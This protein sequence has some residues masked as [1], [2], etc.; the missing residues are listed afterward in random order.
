LRALAV[1]PVLYDNHVVAALNLGSHNAS[2]ISAKSKDLIKTIATKIGGVILR[3]KV[4]AEFKTNAFHDSLTN[5]P[6][7]RLFIKNLMQAMKR[8]KR[9]TNYR[10]AVLFLDID[11][12]KDINDGLG[13]LTGDK[14]IL[15]ISQKLQGCLRA[16]DTLARFG[17][18]EF[19]VLLDGI[20]GMDDAVDAANRI[21]LVLS[22]PFIVENREFYLT[23]SIGVLMYDRKYNSPEDMLRDADT[24]MYKAKL[25][26]KARYAIFDEEMHTRAVKKIHLENDLLRAIETD[27]IRSYYQPLR[28]H[29]PERG[30]IMPVDFISLAEETGAIIPM[31]EKILRE[32]AIQMRL[33]A[34][35]GY[36]LR[37]A[38]NLSASNLSQKNLVT[39][40]EEALKKNNLNGDSIELEITES[41]AMKEFDTVFSTLQSLRAVGSYI[42]IDDFGVGYAPLVYL[43][44]YPVSKIKIDI[45]F[46]RDIPRDKNAMAI[47]EAII[48]MAHILNIQVVAEG[49]ETVE[50]VKFL[51]KHDCDEIQG[52]LFSPAVLPEKIEEFLK[53]R[54]TISHLLSIA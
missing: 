48:T 29:H 14:V 36:N 22:K 30:I 31:T 11:R 28:W 23:G 6:N 15:E 7:R 2:S 18:D 10:F 49:V 21:Q 45:A 20:N 25:A 27:Q 3:L 46:I 40:V 17:G 16:N 33:W 26:G 13:H 39:L 8:A 1:V 5:I 9:S 53:N 35:K 42:S 51:K 41:A 19:T 38:V 43:K 47:T 52:F 34:E 44:Q 54:K 4:E 37:L 12:F 24:A 32:S 50:Q